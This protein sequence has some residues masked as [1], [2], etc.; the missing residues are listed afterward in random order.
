[1]V[2]KVFQSRQWNFKKGI[3][4]NGPNQALSDPAENPTTDRQ[5]GEE[6]RKN[7]TQSERGGAE[8]ECCFS[9][10]ANLIGQASKTGEEEAGDG[11]KTTHEHKPRLSRWFKK[12]L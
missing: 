11:K 6:N 2:I 5:T 8:D 3:E 10:P 12:G 4:T 7:R 1:M 9:N